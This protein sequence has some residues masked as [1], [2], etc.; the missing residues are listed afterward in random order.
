MI[1][2]KDIAQQTAAF[3]LQIEAIKL[4]PKNPFIW[5]SGWKSPIYCDNRVILSYPDIRSYVSRTMAEFLTNTYGQ[6]DIIAGVATGA[7]GIGMLVADFLK[8]PFIYVR[9]EPKGH[10]RQ[11]QIEGKL[12]PGQKVVVIEDLISTG[13][14]SLNA[15]KALKANEANIL[16][17]VAIF[18]YGFKEAEENFKQNGIN[19]NTLSNYNHLIKQAKETNYI[20]AGDE[21]L[22]SQWNANP[23]GWLNK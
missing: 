14:S 21:V 15:V 9:P 23:S 11:N 10:G 12:L 7:I 4:Q 19:L 22:L 3:L 17:M 6:P 5:A 1:I 8:L 16:G 13:K 20:S 18:T 2:S